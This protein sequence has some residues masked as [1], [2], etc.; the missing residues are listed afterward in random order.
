[1]SCDIFSLWKLKLELEGFC[2]CVLFMEIFL[3]CLFMLLLQSF[4]ET[5]DPKIS[6]GH[7]VS[8]TICFFSVLSIHC[9]SPFLL[10]SVSLGILLFLLASLTSYLSSFFWPLLPFLPCRVYS[11]LFPAKR[12]FFLTSFSPLLSS[13][14]LIVETL[15]SVEW[16]LS[17]LHFQSHL[18]LKFFAFISI[19]SRMPLPHIPMTS[20]IQ[21]VQG[22]RNLL[23][24]L[25]NMFLLICISLNGITILLVS[26]ACPKVAL[27]LFPSPST[28][29]RLGSHVQSTF[30]ISFISI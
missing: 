24:F 13:F 18:S 9:F 14:A 7:L 16:K 27:Q 1:M 4:T 23:I 19:L 12:G 5:A 30:K 22:R 10:R 28:S 25:A 26:Q 17:S 15:F 8:K 20:Q 2:F 6:S 11:S 3:A 21:Y 29:S